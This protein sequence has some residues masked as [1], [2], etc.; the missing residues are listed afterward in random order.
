MVQLDLEAPADLQPL[1]VP[2]VARTNAAEEDGAE[3]EE[4][5]H[6]HH[7]HPHDEG[8][9]LVEGDLCGFRGDGSCGGLRGIGTWRHLTCR[10]M[11]FFE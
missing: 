6:A 11:W 8:R 2:I 10:I 4:E 7:H 1:L 5:D 9:L 3:E